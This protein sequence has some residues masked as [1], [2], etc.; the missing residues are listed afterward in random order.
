MKRQAAYLL[1]LI[2]I[3]CFVSQY[4]L[5]QISEGG[6]PISFSLDFDEVEENVKFLK[7]KINENN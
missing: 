7:Q 6:E 5:G 1:I 2:G 3:L 4:S